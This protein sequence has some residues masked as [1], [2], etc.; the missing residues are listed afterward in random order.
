MRPADVLI[1]AAAVAG[2]AVATALLA[3]LAL[4]PTRRAPL[5]WR[6]T[7]AAVAAVVSTAIGVVAIAQAM[8]ISPHDLAVVLA[9][10]GL[11][12]LGGAVVAW[13][14]G[15]RVAREARDVA[16]LAHR[17]GEGEVLDGATNESADVATSAELRVVAAELIAASERLEEA[18]RAG[19]RLESARRQVVS[20]V[21]H[22][23][24]TPLAGLRAMAEALEDGI[25]D[26]PRPYYARIQQQVA[27]MSALVDDL[28][29]FSTI[30]AGT[31]RLALEDVALGDLISDTLA[32]VS[33]LAAAGGVRV[34]GS[35]ADAVT[36]LGDARELSRVLRNLV[37]NAI[38]FTPPDGT[39][40][41]SAFVAGSHAVVR[42]TDAC[43]GIADDDV[44]RL[45]EP[46]WRGDAARTP[47]TAVRGGAG[48]GLSIVQGIVES[49]SGTVVARNVD[50]GCCFEVRLPVAEAGTSGR[51]RAPAT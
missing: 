39:V 15:S 2:S 18:R 12:A 47:S 4:R 5:A 51:R 31:L 20:W 29:A 19:E 7:L 3:L 1:V 46:G 42:V 37:T 49:H 13:V 35:S 17:L 16:R 48:L 22:D 33:P 8:F 40:E 32:E 24:R 44:P 14:L 43:G 23:L 21:S 38:R 6:I 11:G 45:F 36:V 34:D 27:A 50:G 10:V 30:Q 28:L 41:I 25:V 26:D 9:T